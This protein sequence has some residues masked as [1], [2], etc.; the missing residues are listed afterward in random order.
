MTA[1]RKTKINTT[2]VSI[3]GAMGTRSTMEDFHS[4]QARIF[5]RL[6]SIDGA[7]ANRLVMPGVNAYNQGEYQRALSLF[8]ESIMEI[9][10]FA[11]TLIFATASFIL[12]CR[13]TTSN[14]ATHTRIG[15][16]F[17]FS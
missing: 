1:P 12:F 5:A 4:V 6:G 13:R 10:A 14:I 2:F 3:D 17:H 9:P 8:L 16:G 15:R 7:S 11:R